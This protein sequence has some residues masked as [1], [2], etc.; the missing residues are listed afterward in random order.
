MKQLLGRGWDLR[1]PTRSSGGIVACMY[2][3]R[4]TLKC[5]FEGFCKTLLISKTWRVGEDQINAFFMYY[6]RTETGL[7]GGLFHCI[8]LLYFVQVRFLRILHLPFFEQFGGGDD[9]LASCRHL[10][11]SLTIKKRAIIAK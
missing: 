10:Q 3:C 9:L 7:R 5:C 1:V 6:V 2:V 4:Y 8:L 11:K